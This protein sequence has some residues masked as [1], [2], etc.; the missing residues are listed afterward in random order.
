MFSLVFAVFAAVEFK[1]DLHASY[2]YNPMGY[3]VKDISEAL[4]DEENAGRMTSPARAGC[5]R[6]WHLS[7]GIC[8][9][10]SGI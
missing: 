8:L 3:V 5:A 4:F 9:L 10:S 1:F 2:K 7:S 6:F